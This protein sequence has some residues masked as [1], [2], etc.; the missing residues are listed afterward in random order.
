M[1]TTVQLVNRYVSSD[2]IVGTAVVRN[3]FH[4]N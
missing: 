4:F 2:N 3:P 1:P